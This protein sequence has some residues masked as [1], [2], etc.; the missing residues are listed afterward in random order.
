MNALPLLDPTRITVKCI[1]GSTKEFDIGKFPALAGREIV[2]MYPLTAI[3]KVGN[4]AANVDVMLKMM[5]YV[6]VPA[7]L[8]TMGAV[9]APAIRLTSR[10][11]IDNHVPD[12]E[13][14]YQIEFELVRYNTSFFENGKGRS[15]LENLA[16]NLT[17]QVTTA[18]IKWLPQL[19]QAAK[20]HSPS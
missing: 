19:L 1:D 5:A 2:T 18:L 9:Q 4:Y 14:L 16:K 17:G 10:A 8:D 3:P 11:L 6:E 12:F 15:L 13:A 7:V 20:Q